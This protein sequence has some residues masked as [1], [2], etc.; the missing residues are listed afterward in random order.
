MRIL[1]IED[2]EQLCFSIAYQLENQGFHIDTCIDGEDAL[3]FMKENIYDLI[4]L[5]RM[6]PHIDGIT[7][8]KKLR[9]QNN[10]TPVIIL[11]ALGELSDKIMGLDAGADDYLVKPFAIEELLARIRSINRRPRQWTDTD[12]LTYSDITFSPS[13]NSLT[14]SLGTCTL[15]KKEGTL[16]EFFMRNSAQILPRTTLLTKV[17]GPYAEIED[18]NLDNYIHFI[19]RRL[20]AVSSTTTIK[21]HRGVGYR[22]EELHE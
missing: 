10:S 22:L 14:G 12:S 2:D 15:S 19:R 13:T 8:L 17:W 4:L 1:L 11:T 9:Q 16:L 20:K 6:L 3:L 21:T 7:L 5:D 18:G